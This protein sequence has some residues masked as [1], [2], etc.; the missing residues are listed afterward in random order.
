MKPRK[1]NPI[2]RLA[3]FSTATVILWII[4]SVY[5]VLTMK[6]EP[7]VP[8]YILAPVSPQLNTEVLDT[9]QGRLNLSD[10]QIKEVQI[11]AGTGTPIPLPTLGPLVLPTASPAGEATQEGVVAQ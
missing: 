2:V 8:E 7:V 1:K 9:V 6:P 11:E 5:R 3:K 4:F 10:Q